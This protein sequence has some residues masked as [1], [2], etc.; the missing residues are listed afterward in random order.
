VRREADVAYFECSDIPTSW[1]LKC[2]G[3]KWEGEWKNCTPAGEV[4]LQL[5]LLSQ[6]SNTLTHNGIKLDSNPSPTPPN[7]MPAEGYK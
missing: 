4:E 7:I 6:V 5:S 2:V 1:E 3:S